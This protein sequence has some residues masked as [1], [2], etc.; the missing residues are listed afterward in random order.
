MEQA[1]GFSPVCVRSC[2]VVSFLLVNRLGQN[3]QQKAA[4]LVAWTR[5][6][7]ASLA[8]LRNR[9]LQC[10]QMCSIAADIAGVELA[11]LDST[12]VALLEAMAPC[13]IGP[14][15]NCHGGGCMDTTTTAVSVAASALPAPRFARGSSGSASDRLRVCFNCNLV[16]GSIAVHMYVWDVFT[17]AGRQKNKFLL[18]LTI[19]NG[20]YSS[21][22]VA[23]FRTSVYLGVIS[24]L[25]WTCPPALATSCNFHK[26]ASNTTGVPVWLFL[27][28]LD[29][30]R[31]H[32]RGGRDGDSCDP[33]GHAYNA[34]PP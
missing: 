13:K 30:A 27:Q 5:S 8:G 16:K 18:F 23:R 21:T 4:S 22:R 2:R 11:V 7:C 17:A 20:Y 26:A 10:P 14:A 34:V 3:E 29:N 9:F 31:P 15:C 19:R 24:L 33:V 1:Y 28:H 32:G 25:R 6:C 12:S